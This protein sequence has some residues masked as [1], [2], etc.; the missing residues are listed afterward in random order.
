MLCTPRGSSSSMA[1]RRIHDEDGTAA[2]DRWLSETAS[3]RRPAREDTALAVRYTLQRIADDSPGASVEVRV[4]PFGATQIIAGAT[5]RRG[6]PPAVV[7]MDATTWLKLASGLQ[8]WAD[9]IESGHVDASGERADLDSLLPL[10]RS[11]G[12]DA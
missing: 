6:T 12:G 8:L 3:G 7:E 11:N 2:W 10:A 4:I 9:A 5:H 1:V